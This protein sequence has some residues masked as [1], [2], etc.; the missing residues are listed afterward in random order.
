MDQFV[1][2]DVLE[3]KIVSH[4]DNNMPLLWT[5]QQ[6]NEPKNTSK[7]VKKWFEANQTEVKWPAESPDLYPIENIWYQ[8]ELLKHKGPFK[9]PDKLCKANETA[10]DEITQE[11]IDKLIESVP[12]R[13][14]MILKSK[15][16]V[17]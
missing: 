8:V 14:L 9:T 3:E 13:C 7:L 12:K 11:K 10:W 15:S 5:F 17:I 2:C 16:F 6:D 4:A 1:Y